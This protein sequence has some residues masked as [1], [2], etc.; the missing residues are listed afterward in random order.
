MGSPSAGARREE[1]A[2]G[3]HDLVLVQ[4][5]G[6]ERFVTAER[7]VFENPQFSPGGERIAVATGRR[8]GEPTEIWIHD[9]A[10][11]TVSRLTFDG[12]RAPVWTPDG[13][14]VTFSR[15]GDGQGIYTKAADG[16]GEAERLL[17]VDEFHW[18]VGWTPDGHT[19]AFGVL[20]GRTD[21]AESSSSIMAFDGGEPRRVVGPGA[22]WGG[23]LSP[24]GRWLA[25]YT[26]ESG[27]FEVYVTPFP[28]GRPRWLISNEGGRDP[29]WGPDGTEVYYRSGDRLVAA[30]IDT[31]AG[32]RVLARRIML[33]PFSP[34]LYADYDIHPDGRTLAPVRPRDESDREIVVVLDWLAEVRRAAR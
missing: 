7:L 26:L 21:R 5:D 20:E 32:V 17:A 3:A 28:E 8:V 14:A 4:A 29:S 15:P 27:S 23:R 10:A 25:Y 12:G 16:R 2:A 19:L 30:R 24:D 11:G 18:L 22:I 1:H 9:L 33:A 31:T 34:P 6:T 13:A